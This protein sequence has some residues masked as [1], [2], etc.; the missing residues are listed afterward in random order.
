MLRP[1]PGRFWGRSSTSA[2]ACPDPWPACSGGSGE[3]DVRG[4]TFVR[5][6]DA[7]RFIEEVPGDDPEVA[8]YLRIEGAGA[9]GE[10]G[11]ASALAR[12]QRE[13]RRRPPRPLAAVLT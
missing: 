13:L 5:R 6:E 10:L 3:R 9:R 8:S 2:L 7:E 4:A 1:H 11:G 12:V